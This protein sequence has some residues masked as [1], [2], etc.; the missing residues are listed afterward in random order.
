M[1]K[2]LS[3]SSHHLPTPVVQPPKTL[4]TQ[5]RLRPAGG[6]APQHQKHSKDEIGKRPVLSALHL[7]RVIGLHEPKIL[8]AAPPEKR[9]MTRRVSPKSPSSSLS[10]LERELEREQSSTASR[11]VTEATRMA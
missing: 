6:R 2:S 5:G 7:S 1:A 4:T 10:S 3:A 9:G 11:Q 8:P